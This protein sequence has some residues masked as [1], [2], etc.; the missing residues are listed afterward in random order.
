M[1]YE[2]PKYRTTRLDPSHKAKCNKEWHV[3]QQIPGATLK[4]DQ[5]DRQH[6]EGRIR[7]NLTLV[8]LSRQ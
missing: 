1:R 4:D 6:N 7:G 8:N 2:T 3:K 5:E